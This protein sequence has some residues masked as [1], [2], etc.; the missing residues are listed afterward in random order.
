MLL[1][2]VSIYI[3]YCCLQHEYE[4]E[5]SKSR[6]KDRERGRDKDRDRDRV[7]DRE[8][9][10]EK[11][12]DRDRERDREKGHDRYR[13]RHRERSERRERGGDRD[14][15]DHRSRDYDRRRDYDRDR[16]DRTRGTRT[17][18]IVGIIVVKSSGACLGP[19]IKPCAWWQPR[20]TPVTFRLDF[21]KILEYPAK[22]EIKAT[23]VKHCLTTP[24][25]PKPLTPPSTPATAGGGGATVTQP[26]TPKPVSRSEASPYPAYHL[27]SSR[28]Q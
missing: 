1:L 25:I 28:H 13:D 12:R 8:R 21:G 27:C 19:K 4:R 15:D 7:R 23:T 11:S 9:Y 16:E 18:A 17:P 2:C 22:S 3:F 6:S 20:R 5:S 14:E 10:T 26:S 24:S